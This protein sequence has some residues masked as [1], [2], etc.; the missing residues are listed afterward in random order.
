[1]TTNKSSGL[2][3]EKNVDPFQSALTKF[4]VPKP[5]PKVKKKKRKPA[6]KK[7]THT[8]KQPKTS[9]STDI[10]HPIPSNPIPHKEEFHRIRQSKFAFTCE[11]GCHE[12]FPAGSP[13]FWRRI[14]DASNV[15]HTTTICPD[16][17][18]RRNTGL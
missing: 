12:R 9:A 1:M 11:G 2:L 7:A 6:S 16:C 14:V 4:G 17:W 13:V 5:K 15:Y 10:H 18:R 3:K 8:I